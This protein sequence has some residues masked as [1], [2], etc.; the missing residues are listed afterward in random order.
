MLSL[1]IVIVITSIIL[2]ILVNQRN[3]QGTEHFEPIGSTDEVG[4]T[5]KWMTTLYIMQ[6]RLKG[7]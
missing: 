5:Q 4:A 6:P 2:P 7:N 3:A 1:V